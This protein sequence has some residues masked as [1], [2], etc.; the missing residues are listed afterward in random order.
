MSASHLQR[1]PLWPLLVLPAAA[2]QPL[3]T[4][5]GGSAGEGFGATIADAGDQNGDGVP[6]LLIG[7][8]GHSGGRGAVHCVSGQSLGGGSGAL[9]WTY[10]TPSV[11]AAARLGT[12]VALVGDLTGDGVPE[13]AVGAPDHVGIPPDTITGA[14]LV[15][16]GATLATHGF[17]VGPA[18]TRLGIAVAALGDQDG[19]GLADLA[20][21]EFK[22]SLPAVV[23]FVPGSALGTFG[24]VGQVSTNT[25]TDL[26]DE[27]G[28]CLASGFDLDGDGHHDL[29]V[30]APGIPSNGQLTGRA[31]IYRAQPGAFTLGSY[32]SNVFGDRLGSAIAIRHDYDGDGVLDFVVGAPGWSSGLGPQQGRVVVLSGAKLLA[33]APDKVLFELKQPG[34]SA[35][36]ETGHFGAAVL[37]ADDLNGDGVGDI[38][39]GMPDY[40]TTQPLESRRGAIVVFSGATRA[41]IALIVGANFDRLGD[42]LAP[43]TADLDG[44][45]HQDLVYAGS[46]SDDPLLDCGKLQSARL[47]PA[48]PSGYCTP[49]I[50]SQGCAPSMSWSGSP[51]ATAPAPFLLSCASAINQQPG[52]LYYGSAPAAAPFQGGLRCVSAPTQRTAVQSSGGS[53]A[54]TTDCSGQY[55]Y[56]F[57]A[58]IQSGADPLLVIGAEVYCQYWSRDP[59]S[60]SS[61]SLSDAVSFLVNP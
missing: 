36:P 41:R 37:A 24:G 22:S 45:G 56:D 9:L 25:L 39:V 57:N 46:T 16:N 52:L 31:A 7:A 44:D 59:Q 55:G 40:G 17:M 27:F 13:I 23:R 35:Q 19:D 53:P 50:N 61:T 5:S 3:T 8:P 47:F 14:L 4:L 30:G 42:A 20:V 54:G 26:S 48:L 51:S 38:V 29:G 28:A 18:D 32:V 33:G 11:S 6:D 60:P 15:L 43:V 34:P 49:K 12:S 1:L 21:T 2:Q 58:R 10:T